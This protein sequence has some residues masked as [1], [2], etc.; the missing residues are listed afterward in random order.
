L[1]LKTKKSIFNRKYLFFIISRKFSSY[2]LFFD[3]YDNQNTRVHAFGTAMCQVLVVGVEAGV[4]GL[5][6]EPTIGAPTLATETVLA[7]CMGG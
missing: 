3:H 7:P 5:Q 1:Q 2:K 6:A 4:E